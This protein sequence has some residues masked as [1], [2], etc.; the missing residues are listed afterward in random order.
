MK[1]L[2]IV[3]MVILALLGVKAVK[4]THLVQSKCWRAGNQQECE[5]AGCFWRE[6]E[7]YCV[8]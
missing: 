6:A 3:L 5:D 8:R 1:T 4:V 2:L 7:A